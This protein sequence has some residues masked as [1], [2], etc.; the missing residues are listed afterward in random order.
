MQ[1][2]V[3][4]RAHHSDIGGIA[5]GSMSLTKEIFQDGLVIPPVKIVRK[6][7]I[8]EDLLSILLSAFIFLFYFIQKLFKPDIILLF[9]KK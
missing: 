1:F 2:L 9:F 6:G 4:N 8:Q 7:I 5:P 3:A